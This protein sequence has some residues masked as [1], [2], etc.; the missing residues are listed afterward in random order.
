MVETRKPEA[1]LPSYKVQGVPALI[2]TGQ[3]RP[4]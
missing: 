2:T 1:G 3:I 4:N